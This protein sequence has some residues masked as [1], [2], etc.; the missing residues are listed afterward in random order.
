MTPYRSMADGYILGKRPRLQSDAG[1]TL[2]ELLVVVAILGI[3]A[4][5]AIPQFNVYRQR[6][7]DARAVTDLR[8]AATSEEAYFSSNSTYVSCNDATS[9]A[10][11]LGFGYKN[12]V[13]VQLQM[14][15]AVS[16]FTGSASHVNGSGKVWHY[17]NAAGGITN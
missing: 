6:G 11:I 17:D 12:S 3:L 14:T 5:I 1:F 4:A 7:F 2:I 13:G 15:G 9:C 8:N 16:T 10:S